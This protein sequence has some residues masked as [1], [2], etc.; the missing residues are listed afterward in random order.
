ME[1]AGEEAVDGEEVDGV[2]VGLDAFETSV[3]SKGLR[4]VAIRSPSVTVIIGKVG[5]VAGTDGMS[6]ALADFAPPSSCGT[7][8]A[9]PSGLVELRRPEEFCPRRSRGLVQR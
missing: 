4:V 7:A 3:A 9:A 5:S 1:A 8:P 6:W 2:A